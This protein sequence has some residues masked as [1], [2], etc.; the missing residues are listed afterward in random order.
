MGL[1]VEDK[2]EV[3]EIVKS[4]MQLHQLDVQ[5]LQQQWRKFKEEPEARL[6]ALEVQT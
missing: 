3:E 6:A 1:S 2:K 4:V 5:V